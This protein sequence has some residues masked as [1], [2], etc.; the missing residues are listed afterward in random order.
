MKGNRQHIKETRNDAEGGQAI[1]D[2]VL[3]RRW[4]RVTERDDM[5]VDAEDVDESSGCGAFRTCMHVVTICDPAANSPQQPDFSSPTRRS[6][7]CLLFTTSAY[8]SFII[9]SHGFQVI[10]SS[11]MTHKERKR[12]PTKVR[13]HG[14]FIL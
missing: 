10:L 1:D 9:L 8:L 13:D 3:L 6:Y 2:C 4:L 7:S 12:S 14:Q 5:F 11:I